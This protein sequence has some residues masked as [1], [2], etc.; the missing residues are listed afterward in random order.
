MPYHEPGLVVLFA[1][2]KVE[3]LKRGAPNGAPAKVG[4]G[5]LDP[6]VIHLVR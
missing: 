3:C 2:G 5:S 4:P 1:S 6:R